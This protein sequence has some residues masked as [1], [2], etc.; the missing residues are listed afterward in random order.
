MYLLF[1][2]IAVRKQANIVENKTDY[3][4]LDFNIDDGQKPF[5]D[6]NYD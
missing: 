1:F 2:R 6:S 4:Y 3:N 5:A